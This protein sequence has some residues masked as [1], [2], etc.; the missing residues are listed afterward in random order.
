MTDIKGVKRRV[1]IPFDME[2][3]QN[4]G[5]YSD[6]NPGGLKKWKAQK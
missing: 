4:W 3:G 6:A 5:K 1:L 2:I